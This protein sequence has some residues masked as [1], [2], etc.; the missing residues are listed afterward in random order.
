MKL[1]N[2]KPFTPIPG[3]NFRATC[4]DV[5][6]PELFPGY[7][8]G[9]PPVEKIRFAFE[10]DAQT[11]EG[12]PHVI[13]SKPLTPSLHERS[14]LSAF[15]SSW[16]V[17]L[18]GVDEE[19]DLDALVGKGA[20]VVVGHVPGKKQGQ[21]WARLQ[22]IGPDTNPTPLKLSGAYKRPSLRRQEVATAPA[23]LKW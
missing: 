20:F 7:G 8:P 11:P 15:L 4:C 23:D 2:K 12:T 21:T 1:S 6:P 10:L 17:P 13:F 19:L 3:G 22:F 5:L 9:D 16:G 18:P 14:A